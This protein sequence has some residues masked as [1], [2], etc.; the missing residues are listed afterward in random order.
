MRDNALLELLK[1]DPHSPPP[2]RVTVPLRNQASFYAAFG[3]KAGDRMYIAPER[4][5]TLW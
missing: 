4:R 1:S 2:L 5:V 3:V